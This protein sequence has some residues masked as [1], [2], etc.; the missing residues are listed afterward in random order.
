[1]R[2]FCFLFL[3]L[4]SLPP[5]I[6]HTNLCCVFHTCISLLSWLCFCI[7]LNPRYIAGFL[8]FTSQKCATTWDFGFLFHSPDQLPVEFRFSS[9]PLPVLLG[10][11]HQTPLRFLC[12]MRLCHCVGRFQSVQYCFLWPV[13]DDGL[14]TA[15]FFSFFSPFQASLG[16]PSNTADHYRSHFWVTWCHLLLLSGWHTDKQNNGDLCTVCGSCL[17][18]APSSR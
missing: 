16:T 9:P 12:P 1:M 5:P 4:V 11:F 15:V 14:Y 13:W 7:S 17:D 18:S 6:S 10:F 2:V 3:F 8:F